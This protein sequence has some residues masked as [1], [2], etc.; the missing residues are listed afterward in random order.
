MS[1]TRLTKFLRDQMDELNYDIDEKDGQMTEYQMGQFDM[2]Y[3]VKAVLDA[4]N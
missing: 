1:L 3:A 2:L 4:P